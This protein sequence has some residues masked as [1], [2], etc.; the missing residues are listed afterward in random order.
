MGGNCPH[1]CKDGEEQ[2]KGRPAVCRSWIKQVT[3]STV[4]R[5]FE[6][7]TSASCEHAAVIT[8]R[9]PPAQRGAAKPPAPRF[10]TSS[11]RRLWEFHLGA[12]I[13]THR[14]PLL[15]CGH[16]APPPAMPQL[17]LVIKVL[18]S[19]CYHSSFHGSFGQTFV[20]VWL[21]SCTVSQKKKKS[22][23]I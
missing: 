10:Q 5:P 2:L 12:C 14:V 4:Q 18:P 17:L 15:H 3:I 9:L 22:S 13:G 16:A 1:I 8:A 23:S 11:C 6:E 20:L 7:K 19:I 21:K